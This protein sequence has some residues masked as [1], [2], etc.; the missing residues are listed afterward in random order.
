MA[1]DRPTHADRVVTFLQREYA[2][3]LSEY[4]RRYVP[5][6]VSR[7]L[8]QEIWLRVVRCKQLLGVARDPRAY[9]GGIAANVLR[10]YYSKSGIERKRVNIGAYFLQQE[11]EVR[12]TPYDLRAREER[13]ATIRK[14]LKV[15]PARHADVL[16]LI[17]GEGLSYKEAAARLQL[18]VQ[19][20]ER[21]LHEA[22]GRMQVL[23][24]KLMERDDS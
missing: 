21:Y 1:E 10:D 18:S 9:L 23:L 5:A 7:E 20:V 8:R 22:K 6:P 12:D 17:K 3:D 15:L 16:Y 14:A 2:G 24:R 4:L 19:Q 11:S 13:N